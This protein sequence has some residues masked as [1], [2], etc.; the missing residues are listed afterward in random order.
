MLDFSGSWALT[1]FVWAFEGGSN[2]GEPS[3]LAVR[4]ACIWILYDA[5][6]L[7]SKI[8]EAQAE[9]NTLERW[10]GWKQGLMNVRPRFVE[11]TTPELISHA[12][13]CMQRLDSQE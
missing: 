3:E 8:A 5:D 7:W 10:I 1:A 12:L 4:L 6:K 9:H 13:R 11:G 2:V